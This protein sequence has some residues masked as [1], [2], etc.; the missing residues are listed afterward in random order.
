LVFKRENYLNKNKTE[1]LEVKNM[2]KKIIVLLLILGI[3]L[4][5][6]KISEEQTEEPVETGEQEEPIVEPEQEEIE[7]PEEPIEEEPAETI[8]PGEE[9]EEANATEPEKNIFKI[10]IDNLT[11]SQK[12]VTI[13]RGTTVVWE[14]KGGNVHKLTIYK[15]V[16][17]LAQSPRLYKGDS[18]EYTFDEEGKYPYVCAIFPEN[19]MGTITVE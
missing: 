17:G 6:C 4:S 1:V 8:E 13:E 10:E 3:M 5:G 7:E 15:Q 11:L 18:F 12:D 9:K 19:I 14:N 16:H 2:D